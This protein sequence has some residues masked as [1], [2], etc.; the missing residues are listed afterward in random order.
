MQQSP[1]TQV[2]HLFTLVMGAKDALPLRAGE[3]VSATV[4]RVNPDNTAAVRVKDTVLAVQ[5]EIPLEP[6]TTVSLRVERQE[7]TIYLRLAGNSAEG[8]DSVKNALLPLMN[9]FGKIGSGTESMARLVE[10]LNALPASLKENLPEIAIINRFLVQVEQLSGATLKD[11]VQNGGVYFE[12]KL[13]ILALG[14]EAD[15]TSADIEA[16]NIITNDLKASLLR[17]KETFLSPTVLENAR[18]TVRPD[19]MIDALNTVLRNIEYYQVQSK[20][21][22]SLQFFLPLV[23]KQLKDGEIILR[24]S[25]RGKPGERCHSCTITLDLER[26]GKMRVDLLSQGGYVHINVSAENKAFSQVVQDASELLGQ[27]FSKAGL[28]LGNLHVHHQDRIEFSGSSASGLSIR[29]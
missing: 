23:W 13:R 28:R 17:L 26:A 29:V 16:R 2:G 20:M 6:G 25:D 4:L 9:S 15:G 19:E 7:N 12:S 27:Q 14:I 1:I 10:L 11:A 3:V 5:T 22:D 24:E 8:A 18:N 21:T